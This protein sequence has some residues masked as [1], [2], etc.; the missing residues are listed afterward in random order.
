MSDP[1][2]LFPDARFLGVLLDGMPY[3]TLIFLNAHYEALSVVLPAI[4]NITVW[5]CEINTVEPTGKGDG[6]NS[7]GAT[8]EV[9]ARSVTLMF[10]KRS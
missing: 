3:P 10:G 7:P 1:D 8:F 6:E 4:S 2:W 5:R 9:P